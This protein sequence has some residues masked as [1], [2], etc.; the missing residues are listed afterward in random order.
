[1]HRRP[2]TFLGLLVEEG[3][4]TFFFASFCIFLRC[5]AKNGSKIEPNSCQKH[6]KIVPKAS[7]MW[8]WGHLGP[9]SAQS[10]VP[11]AQ[12]WKLPFLL[13]RF[14]VPFWRPKSTPNRSKTP[15]ERL[16]F[17][18]IFSMQFFFD[19]G[20]IFPPNLAPE[21]HQNGRKIGSKMPSQ[22]DLVLGSIFDRF[23]FPTWSHLLSKLRKI[24]VFPTPENQKYITIVVPNAFSHFSTKDLEILVFFVRLGAILDSS[25]Y[26]LAS[27]LAPKI[28]QNRFKNRSWKASIFRSFFA[29][30]FWRFLADLGSI[31]GVKLD[32][33]WPLFQHEPGSKIGRKIDAIFGSLFGLNPAAR[34]NTRSVWRTIFRHF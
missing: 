1:M 31:L 15:S 17:C 10:R 25:W 16:W 21:P 30:I 26:Q 3:I 29:S 14:W 8:S 9:R 11:E 5:L 28:H 23:W 2:L 22:A 13:G 18:I 12:K 34:R 24:D 20:S 32:P 27:I 19:L 7:K 6:P 4:T 33:C